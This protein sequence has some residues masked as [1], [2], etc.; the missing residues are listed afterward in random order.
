MVSGASRPPREVPAKFRRALLVYEDKRFEGHLGVDP[1]AIAR[2]MKLNASAWAG[3]E[4]RQHA[5]DAARASVT[6]VGWRRRTHAAREDRRDVAGAAARVR[7]RQERAAGAVRRQRAVRW[8]RG[9][10]RG[11]VMAIL[12]PRSRTTCPGRKPP[13]SR[14]CPTILR[15][16]TSRA[17]A[18][19]CRRSATSCCSGSPP[20]AIS[21]RS[22]STSRSP[23]RWRPR[24]TRCRISRRTC[25]KRLRAQYPGTPSAAQHAR[26]AAA[27]ERDRAAQRTFGGALAPA[28]V[29][30]RRHRDRQRD[31]RGAGLR[32]Q[33]RWERARLAATPSTSSAGR[34]ARA[35]SSSRCS[36]PP[37]SRTARS[38]RACCCPTCRRTT[39]ASRPKTSTTSTA[40]PCAP[41]KRSRI[42]STCRRCAC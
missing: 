11:R 9:R 8:Q 2:A 34:A 10:A 21:R 36:T 42:R 7:F 31:V 18:R 19:G 13:R 38:R 4:R 5:D 22:I 35:A 25:S 41:T 30:R 17:T 23:N 3:G 16:C 6:R 29:Q 37:C 1:L 15:W 28:G 27:G 26:C 24:R 20:R 12:R 14:C 39:R 40:A 32:R 33:Q